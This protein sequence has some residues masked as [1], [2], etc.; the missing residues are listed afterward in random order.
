MSMS[1]SYESYVEDMNDAVDD[2][3][4][5]LARYLPHRAPDPEIA[6]YFRFVGLPVPLEHRVRMIEGPSL[7][8]RTPEPRPTW[9]PSEKALKRVLRLLYELPI[10]IINAI[11]QTLLPLR[12][13]GAH[14]DRKM[15]DR[16][17]F[18]TN[19][20]YGPGY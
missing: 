4:H 8:P 12:Y 15:S 13:H 10:E 19:R 17:R 6:R 11:V 20:R 16:M 7:R 14:R 3:L 2:P 9:S 5:A 1:F 18:L